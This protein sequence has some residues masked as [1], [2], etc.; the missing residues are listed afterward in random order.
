MINFVSS[1]IEPGSDD[2]RK[3]KR[4]RHA[5]T[6]LSAGMGPCANGNSTLKGALDQAVLIRIP[7][8]PCDRSIDG[9]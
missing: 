7:A 6:S 2:D 4:N 8:V 5:G 1:S 9:V 3:P